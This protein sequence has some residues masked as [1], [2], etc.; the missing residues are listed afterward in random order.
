MLATYDLRPHEVFRIANTKGIANDTGKITILEDS[1]TG[2][3]DVWPL[4]NEWRSQ[5]NLAEVVF[6]RIRIEGR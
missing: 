2:R 4:P 1:K 5:F 6:P 3:R